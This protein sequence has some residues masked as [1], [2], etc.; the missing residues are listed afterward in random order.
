MNYCSS[1]YKALDIYSILREKCNN[2][3]RLTN[4]EIF[5]LSHFELELAQCIIKDFNEDM[6]FK[7]GKIL[8]ATA[9]NHYSSL[10]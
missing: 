9:T 6:A 3:E 7:L 4:D 5:T 10:K 8:T 2:N 1:V